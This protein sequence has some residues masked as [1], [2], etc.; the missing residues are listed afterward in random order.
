VG[1]R[2]AVSTT[3]HE[4]LQVFAQK[5]SKMITREVIKYEA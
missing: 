4:T 5:I 3:K 1:P 2:T